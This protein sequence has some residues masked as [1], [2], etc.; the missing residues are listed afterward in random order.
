MVNW[1]KLD[2]QRLVDKSIMMYKIV[3]HMVPEYLCSRF[4][5]RSDTLTDKLRGSDGT[6]A[7]PQPHTNYCKR[8]LSYSGVVLWNSLSLNIRQSLSLNQFKS[9]LKNYD[10]DSGLI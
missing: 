1:V 9:K 4:V 7:I 8:S 5:F 6:L 10:F 2:R 3:I